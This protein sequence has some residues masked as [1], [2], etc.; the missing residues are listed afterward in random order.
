MPYAVFIEGGFAIHGTMR[1]NWK[2]LGQRASHGCVRLHPDNAFIVNR[3][4]RQYGVENTWI[5]VD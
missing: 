4:V 2:Y 3:L 1:S 5:Q